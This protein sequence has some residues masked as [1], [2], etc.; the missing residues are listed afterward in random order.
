M[1]RVESAHL[2]LP[3]RLHCQ[4]DDVRSERMTTLVPP[5]AAGD[6]YAQQSQEFSIVTCAS[7][8]GL[9][10]V[11]RLW[12]SAPNLN[13]GD[14]V[15]VPLSEERRPEGVLLKTWGERDYRWTAD[16]DATALTIDTP[17]Q[18]P[19]AEEIAAA[20]TAKKK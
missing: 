9:P 14:V 10:F 18:C 13:V 2:K 11:L 3:S 4:I 16:A 12:G 19:T 17:A 1:T 6:A 5:K 7:E 20:A 15:S 8:R